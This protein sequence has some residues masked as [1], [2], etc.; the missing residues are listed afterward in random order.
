MWTILALNAG[1]EAARAGESGK[2][3][4]V[5]AQEIGELA[6]KSSD[7]V[8][9]INEI[10]EK[11]NSETNEAVEKVKTGDTAAND[12][13]VISAEV[14]KGFDDV[15]KGF[16][17]NRESIEKQN[18]MIQNTT[19]LFKDIQKQMDVISGISEEQA[20]YAEEILSK[21]Q[22]QNENTSKNTEL[23]HEINNLSKKLMDFM[24]EK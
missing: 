23:M 5:V 4:A 13:S 6:E 3:F 15:L 16:D 10:I 21:I 7:T 14:S 12:G 11:L 19:D 17:K 24:K 1:I 2:G 8:N 18:Q 9:S 20:A 22:E